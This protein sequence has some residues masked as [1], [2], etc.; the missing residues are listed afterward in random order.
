MGHEP[1]VQ[2][3]AA[4]RPTSSGRAAGRAVRHGGNIMQTLNLYSV[5]SE[6][7]DVVKVLM[8][9][10]EKFIQSDR[11]ADKSWTEY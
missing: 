6:T 11:S 1:N 9:L 4:K 5:K 8:K 2:S 7:K 3:R 10:L